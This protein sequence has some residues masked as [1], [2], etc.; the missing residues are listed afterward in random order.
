MIAVGGVNLPAAPHLEKGVGQFLAGGAA[1]K[2]GSKL[3]GRV[4]RSRRVHGRE[5][6]PLNCSPIT[7]GTASD[8][9]RT[10][11]NLNPFWDDTFQAGEVIAVEPGLYSAELRGGIRLENNYLL[12]ETGV[13][14]LTPFPM[15]L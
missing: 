10:T 14:L 11:V 7:W 12:T 9:F 1:G 6:E 8:F 3:P 4:Q 5:A 15:E 13:E 2:A